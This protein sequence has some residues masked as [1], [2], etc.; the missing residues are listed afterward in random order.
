M[1][2]LTQVFDQAA[3]DIRKAMF[4]YT[5][6]F[7]PAVGDAVSD[8]K[9]NLI[10]GTEYQPGSIEAQVWGSEKTIEYLLDDIGREV[11]RDETFLIGTT[12]YTVQGIQ[13][14]DGR[15]VKAVVTG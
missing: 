15:F 7:T 14:N 1:A 2:S 5:A 6:T 8:I 12:T 10:T 4:E 11:N 3:I 13:E 9:V